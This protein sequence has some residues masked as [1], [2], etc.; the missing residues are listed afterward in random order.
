LLRENG[1]ERELS[2]SFGDAANKVVYTKIKYLFL[3]CCPVLDVADMQCAV[4]IS[5]REALE[6]EICAL[7]EIQAC[8]RLMRML[9]SMVGTTS[10]AL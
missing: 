8:Y 7:W 3:Y 9:H 2:K 10:L 5:V 6:N 1:E 4:S